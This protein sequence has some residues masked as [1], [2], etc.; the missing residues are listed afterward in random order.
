MRKRER[1][2]A[3]RQ[4][5]P[6][7]PKQKQN[8]KVRRSDLHEAN[9]RWPPEWLEEWITTVASKVAIQYGQNAA[10]PMDD[11]GETSEENPQLISIAP[12]QEGL[13]STLAEE[14]EN[15]EDEEDEALPKVWDEEGYHSKLSGI[16]GYQDLKL[17]SKL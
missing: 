5:S 11:G 17:S 7:A 4:M 13:F 15:E 14:D 10:S 16:A 1:E 3:K 6:D 9:D 2:D 8:K 12:C